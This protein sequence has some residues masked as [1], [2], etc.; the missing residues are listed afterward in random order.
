MRNPTNQHSSSLESYLIKPVQRVLKY[1]L[2][3]RELV[4]LTDPESPEHTHLTGTHTHTHTHTQ[5]HLTGSQVYLTY[6]SPVLHTEAL[7]A[8]EKVA[9]HINEMQKIYEEYGSVFDQLA[10]EQIGPHRQ[11]GTPETHR[12]SLIPVSPSVS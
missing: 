1:P 8:M 6:N 11:V 12:T 3:L 9:S 2:L 5:T 10:A 7:R 4:S